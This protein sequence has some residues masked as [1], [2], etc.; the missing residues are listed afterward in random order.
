[1]ALSKLKFFETLI[2]FLESTSNYL[3]E[4]FISKSNNNSYHDGTSAF[5]QFFF[6]DGTTIF[7][8]DFSCLTKIELVLELS[9]NVSSSKVNFQNARPYGLMERGI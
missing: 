2:M 1:M 8:R 4:Y 9:Q 3:Q 6:S 5:F 7:L